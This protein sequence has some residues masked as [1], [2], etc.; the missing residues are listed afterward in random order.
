MADA[1]LA[2]IF[3]VDGVQY[4]GVRIP[5]TDGPVVRTHDRGCS[6][7]GRGGEEAGATAVAPGRITQ[8]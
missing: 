2:A 1:R 5:D 8:A 6:R 3:T 4:N 7:G